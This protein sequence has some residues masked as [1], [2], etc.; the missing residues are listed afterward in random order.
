MMGSIPSQDANLKGV[1][2]K[3]EIKTKSDIPRGL[4][5]FNPRYGIITKTTDTEFRYQNG[6]IVQFP[7]FYKY[8]FFTIEWWK[9]NK[10]FFDMDNFKINDI[11]LDFF[12]DRQ[13]Q[14]II[15]IDNPSDFFIS[16]I[17]FNNH[18]PIQIKSRNRTFFNNF[19]NIKDGSQ[20]INILDF[21]DPV[22]DYFLPQW[23]EEAMKI[24]FMGRQQ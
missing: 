3:L 10:C 22:E 4:R 17:H 18:N 14:K 1:Y 8:F 13:C 7:V 23:H 11:I 9:T 21:V 24:I 15:A 16:F 19:I 5:F 6:K 20:Q 2:M 12:M